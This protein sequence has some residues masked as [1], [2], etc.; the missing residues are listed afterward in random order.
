MP[1]TIMNVDQVARYLHMDPMQI[2]RMVRHGEIPCEHA[3]ARPIFRRLEVDAWASQHILGMPER[4]LARYHQETTQTADS[5]LDN[6]FRIGAMLTPERTVI[7]LPSRTKPSVLRDL[8]GIADAADLLYDPKD[9][10]H[11][12]EE[13]EALHSTGLAHG[14]A[15]VHPRHHDPFLADES[16][17]V[18]ARTARPIH[19]GAPD[20]KPT[21]LFVLLVCQDDRRHLQAL[22]RLC[23]LFCKTGLLDELRAV[24][25]SREMF[26]ALQAAESKVLTRGPSG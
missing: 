5:D 14:I 21:D 12:L 10:L 20:G 1:Q 17:L 2:A 16:F 9:L 23:T 15:I 3:G 22:A 11:S 13:R 19:F 4:R 24:A 18:L 6:I 8:T 7:D 26:E 25:S